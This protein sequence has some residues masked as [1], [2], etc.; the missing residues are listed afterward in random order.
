MIRRAMANMTSFG[1]SAPGVHE[2]LNRD[3]QR[4]PM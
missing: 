1:R 2:D 3:Y 4:I